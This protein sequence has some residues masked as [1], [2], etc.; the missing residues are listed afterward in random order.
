MNPKGLLVFCFDF[1]PQHPVQETSSENCRSLVAGM[2]IIVCAKERGSLWLNPKKSSRFRRISVCPSIRKSVLRL[3]MFIRNSS[4]P[5]L[6]PTTARMFEDDLGYAFRK[7]NSLLA[8]LYAAPHRSSRLRRIVTCIATNQK[9][10]AILY[11]YLVRTIEPS[12]DAIL[13]M[14]RPSRIQPLK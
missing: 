14:G 9:N 7:L 6:Y 11:L 12:K 5:T 4:H 3:L 1:S 10:H 2:S 13:L 8:Q